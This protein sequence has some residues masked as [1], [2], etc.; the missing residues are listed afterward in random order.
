MTRV[1]LSN[2][3]LFL[4]FDQV[5]RALDRVSKAATDGYPAHRQE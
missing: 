2:N 4:G 1:S 5:E 3:P